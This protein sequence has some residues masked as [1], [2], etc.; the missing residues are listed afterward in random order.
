[1]I[2]LPLSF[3]IFAY[4]VGSIPTGY[5]LAKLLCDIDI[6][7]Y[8]SGNIGATNVGR[9][10]G[11]KYF[12]IVMLLD[13][14]KAYA[15]LV[16]ANNHIS[17]ELWYLFS[18]AGLLL[19]GNAH[20]LFLQFRGGKGVATVL[21]ILTFFVPFWMVLIFC[22]LWLPIF[23]IT[24]FAFFASLFAMLFIFFIYLFFFGFTAITFFLIILFFWLVSRHK[25]NI[26]TFVNR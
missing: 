5:W 11:K 10:L 23:L 25:T 6:Q 4:I 1:M 19:L 2:F 16:V 18:V 9:T 26:T 20:S 21:G 7:E 15:T 17:N 13:A 14:L 12:F 8:G 22:L 3:L 24:A